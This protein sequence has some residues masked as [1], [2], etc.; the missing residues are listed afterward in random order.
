MEN[1]KIRKSNVEL[2]RVILMLMILVLHYN[3]EQIGG[4]FSVLTKDNP[5]YYIQY[6]LESAFAVSVNCFVL[7]TGYFN[8]SE[9][10]FKIRKPIDLILLVLFYNI[11]LYLIAV[12]LKKQVFTMH[13]LLS[14][15][16]QAKWFIVIFIALYCIAPFINVIIKNI[17]E[18][19]YKILLII[20]LFLFSVYPSAV[21]VI[22]DNTKLSTTTENG[23]GV[24]HFVLMY[25][26][27]G[28][29]RKYY[30]INKS[31]KIY[32]SVYLILSV[33]IFVMSLFTKNVW[34]YNNTLIVFSSIILFI[35]FQKID[36]QSNIINY[37]S[38]SVLAVF[39]IHTDRSLIPN[40][41]AVFNIKEYCISVFLIP[42]EIIT[43]ICMFLFCIVIDSIRRIVFKHTLDKIL[44]KIKF[45]NYVHEVD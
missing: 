18:K 21:A 11:V 44:N 8:I 12:V 36:F 24:I 5:N 6:F 10:K 29:I 19:S 40:F 23:Y 26:I 2:L 33:L 14:F 25:L 20:S 1:K 43:T 35:I 31:K 3:Y 37:I 41:W 30:I 28:Y 15:S 42:N 7:I 13:K 39:I 32:L 45:V 4:A 16:I 38:K 22:S 9:N 17:N 34:N 27:G